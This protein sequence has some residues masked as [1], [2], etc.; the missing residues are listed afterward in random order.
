MDSFQAPFQLKELVLD[1][2]SLKEFQNSIGMLTHLEYLVL[3]GGGDPM[4]IEWKSFTK[5]LRNLSNLR[6]LVLCD[7]RTSSGEFSFSN[8]EYNGMSPA[9]G[10]SSTGL[11]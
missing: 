1:A 7:F 2:V 10:P 6:R 4:R 5:S 8:I 3:E 11:G 9:S